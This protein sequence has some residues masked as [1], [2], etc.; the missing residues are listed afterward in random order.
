MGST[1]H[2]VNKF[3]FVDIE[4]SGLEMG[5]LTPWGSGD[6]LYQVLQIGA[7]V[8]DGNFNEV[9]HIKIE[10]QFNEEKYAWSP[11]AEAVHGLTREYLAA[12]G[13]HEEEA[14]AAFCEFVY[15]WF[16][17]SG[18]CVGGT[19]AGTFDKPWL[20]HWIK[21]HGIDFTFGHRNIDTFPLARVLFDAHDS[22]ETFAV[23]GIERT[24]HDALSDV[25][26]SLQ[27]V[28]MVKQLW[29]TALERT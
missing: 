19:N 9:D 18:I 6:N 5:T 13:M 20:Q 7:I 1:K 4:T 11:K 17:K 28:Q 16:G 10:I 15:R 21:S 14:V 27:F 12:N 22:N 3:L 29:D 26:A 24:T 8:C 2:K 25:R 23:L